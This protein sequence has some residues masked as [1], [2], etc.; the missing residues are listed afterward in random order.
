VEV[1]AV[2][3]ELW[4]RRVVVS[5]GALLAATLG[6]ALI[7]KAEHSSSRLGVAAETLMVDTSRSEL[8]NAAPKR[9]ENLT[10][11]TTLLGYMVESPAVQREIAHKL[12]IRPTALVVALPSIEAPA[13]PTPLAERAAATAAARPEPYTLSVGLDYQL[14]LIWLRAIAPDRETAQR[15]IAAAT[16]HLRAAPDRIRD[17]KPSFGI[18]VVS[19]TRTRVIVRGPRRIIA[20]VLALL[21]FAFWCCGAL[22]VPAGGRASRAGPRALR[23]A[24]GAG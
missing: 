22:F 11:A 18:R 8:V 6:A 12:G 21:A 19:P 3:A 15:L 23:V 10:R 24:R 7:A 4:R 9:S 17:G 16:A 5:I 13:A 2:L 1:F 14:P 20:I